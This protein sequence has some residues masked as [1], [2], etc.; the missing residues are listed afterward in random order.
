M[1]DRPCC[2]VFDDD[3]DVQCC[4]NDVRKLD[5]HMTVVTSQTHY[6]EQKKLIKSE[7]ESL[8]F[9]ALQKPNYFIFES[10][11]FVT[12]ACDGI[13]SLLMSVQARVRDRIAWRPFNSSTDAS[14]VVCIR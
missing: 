5:Y 10:G 11:F 3:D 8:L 4:S 2:S 14:L 9:L 7:F 6:A 12:P 13:S 1:S